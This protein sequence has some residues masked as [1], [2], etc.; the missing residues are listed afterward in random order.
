MDCGTW[1]RLE[2]SGAE[3]YQGQPRLTEERTIKPGAPEKTYHGG[4]CNFFHHC[5]DA[6]RLRI[7]AME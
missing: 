1:E 3:I 7:S 2:F 6:C 5:A 4:I